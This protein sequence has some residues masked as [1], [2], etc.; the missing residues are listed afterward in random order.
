MKTKGKSTDFD[1]R[2][3]AIMKERRIKLDITQEDVGEVLDVT[4]QQVQKYESGVNRMSV[5]RFYKLCK[6]LDIDMQ[7]AVDAARGLKEV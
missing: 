7:S 6:F 1:K 5:E 3:G 4:F 2:L